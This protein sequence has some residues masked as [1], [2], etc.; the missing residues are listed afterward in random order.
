MIAKKPPLSF[1]NFN[2][3]RQNFNKQH[4]NDNFEF[5]LLKLNY[6][7]FIEKSYYK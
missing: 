1:T 4:L 6:D 7:F 5:S 2:F 3:K